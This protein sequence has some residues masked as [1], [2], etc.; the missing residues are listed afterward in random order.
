MLT[1]TVMK[2]GIFVAAL[3]STDHP[4]VQLG[5]GI[6]SKTNTARLPRDIYGE[7]LLRFDAVQDEGTKVSTD[8]LQLQY[9]VHLDMVGG[10]SL[11]QCR[12]SLPYS[13]AS[14]LK[15]VSQYLRTEGIQKSSLS[16][17]NRGKT[18]PPESQMCGG[19]RSKETDPRKVGCDIRAAA[20]G[21]QT[22]GCWSVF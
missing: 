15:G 4:M 8:S 1:L 2:H 19:F 14:H 13:W 17:L 12:V 21:F 9:R 3:G 20:I 16:G 10:Q 11:A 22:R 5:K 6:S 7:A 18:M